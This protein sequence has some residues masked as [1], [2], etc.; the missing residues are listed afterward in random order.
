MATTAAATGLTVQQWDSQYFRESL[1]A[2]IF[3]P[4]MGTKSNSIIQVKEDLTKK[5]GDSVTFAMRNKL[6]NAATT[7]S[8]TLEGNEEK[9]VT[10]SQKVTID[11]YRNA[12]L[13]PVLE[14][15]FSAIPLR[16]AGKDALM[17]WNME[18]TR[19]K[20]IT[21]LG[22]IN[23]VDYGDAT[24][25]QK[26]AWLVDNADRV[27]F[28]AAL[29]NDSG[30]GDHS[31]ALAN[32]DNT[33]DQLT[34]G[35]ISLMKRLAKT[36]SPKIKP[37]KPRQG[38]VTSD[39]YIMYVP[40]L[41]LRDLTDDSDFLQA[42]RE[43][44]NRGKLNPIFAGADY[45]YDNVAIIEVEDIEVLTGVGNGGIDV[46]PVYFCGAQAVAMAWGK[47]PESKEED[48]DYGDKQG[49]AVRQ[50][51]EINKMIFGSSES[52]D[53]GDK[54]DHG[55]VTGFFASVADS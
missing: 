36:A 4:Y 21:A 20:I 26:D 18:L 6:K 33:A 43:A 11:Q 35:A 2:N 13:I 45:I 28:G 37:L 16:E 8:N 38:G 34:P 25:P 39:S 19:D 12:V 31:A 32:I 29:S 22:Q 44:R 9:L 23:G 53:T 51:Y 14:E 10:R 1:N 46:A 17:D 3:K 24:E 30:P 50:W 55:V 40:S 42:N 5:P 49:I 7:G 52:S 48:F 15:Q 54:K 27:L 47:R 41:V